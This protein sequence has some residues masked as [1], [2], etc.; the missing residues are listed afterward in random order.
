MSIKS[1]LTAF[2]SM[3]TLVVIVLFVPTLFVSFAREMMS[4][5]S[6]MTSGFTDFGSAYSLTYIFVVGLVFIMSY[7]GINADFDVLYGLFALS[8]GNETWSFQMAIITAIAI[9]VGLYITTSNITSILAYHKWHSTHKNYVDHRIQ[10]TLNGIFFAACFIST[11]QLSNHSDK[12]VKNRSQKVVSAVSSEKKQDET[13][14]NRAF[15]GQIASLEADFARDSSFAYSE[16]MSAAQSKTKAERINIAAIEA[17]IAEMKGRK[18][19]N[20]G[21]KK[22]IELQVNKLGV[23]IIALNETIKTK[24]SAVWETFNKQMLIRSQALGAKKDS[25]MNLHG[26]SMAKLEKKFED[27]GTALENDVKMAGSVFRWRN[28]I[29]NV[30]VVVL[31]LMLSLYFKGAAEDDSTVTQGGGSSGNGNGNGGPI[32]VII[33]DFKTPKVIR[34]RGVNVPPDKNNNFGG[35]GNDRG[36]E[37]NEQPERV[38]LFKDFQGI[39]KRARTRFE[40]AYTSK[41]EDSR[42]LNMVKALSDV[43]F[44]ISRGFS[45]SELSGGLSLVHD[46][47]GNISQK[48]AELLGKHAAEIDNYQGESNDLEKFM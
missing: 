25:I 24:E 15:S 28:I 37:T 18:A 42:L 29:F 7:A 47:A 4:H 43:R 11:M 41:T 21:E 14:K 48:I 12:A 36:G 1:N 22:W 26:A 40:R 19:K 46:G 34:T 8:S 45:V 39:C 33:P 20:W 10:L 2:F 32:P 44:L 9:G 23:S 6:R 3:K 5:L 27:K 31:T 35:G 16:A 13:A 17:N 38:V 30:M